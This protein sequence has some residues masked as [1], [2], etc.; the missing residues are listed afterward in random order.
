MHRYVR[1][2]AKELLTYPSGQLAEGPISLLS[3]YGKALEPLGATIRLLNERPAVEWDATDGRWKP[4]GEVQVL[5]LA[6]GEQDAPWSPHT[7]HH[8]YLVGTNFRA[9]KKAG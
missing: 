6:A 4:T 7:L 5:I 2:D 8:S 3:E 1:L 9:R